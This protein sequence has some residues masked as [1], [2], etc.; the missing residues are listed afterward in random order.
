MPNNHAILSASASHRWIACP[1]S[2]LLCAQEKDTPSEY[3]LEGT[4]A[5]ALCEHKLQKALKMPSECDVNNLAFYGTEMEECS[6][7]YVQ[8]VMEQ[9]A[10]AQEKCQDSRIMIEERLDFSRWVPKGF[11]T[12]DCII[13]SDGDVSVIDFKYGMG[14]AVEAENNSQMLCYALG[15]LSIY[16]GIY[17]ISSVTMSIFQP[18]RENI[19][20]WSISKEELLHW[21]ENTLKPR[22]ELAIKGEGDFCAGEHCRFC[23]VKAT[24]RKRAEYNLALARYDF[25]MPNELMDT[26]VE[27]VLT[28][29]D[30]L[31]AWANDVKDY[32]LKE[33]LSG[34]KWSGYKVVEGRSTRK[35]TNEDEVASI[36]LGEGYEPYEYKLL[37][38]TAM[39]K[40]LGKK[41]FEELLSGHITRAKGKPALVPMSDK[42]KEF[43]NVNEDFKEEI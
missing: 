37:G 5:H 13:L 33:A 42:R 28:K 40:L 10:S 30:Q 19:S 17:D 14:V 9:F 35:Y 25:I 43:K 11:G 18:R 22:A 20:T 24:C 15:V 36:L 34:K 12:G 27:A 4:A 7:Q 41:R 26:E 29:V 1:P 39:T 32:A 8:F 2:A 3:A 16:D 23:K 6:E 38:I 31:V 21:A